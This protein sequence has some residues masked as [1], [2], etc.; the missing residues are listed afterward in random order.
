[1]DTRSRVLPYLCFFLS[2]DCPWRDK[3]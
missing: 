1:V 2:R 3:P